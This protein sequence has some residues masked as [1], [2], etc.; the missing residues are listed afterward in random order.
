MTEEIYEYLFDLVILGQREPLNEVFDPY[1]SV[2]FDILPDQFI[3]VLPYDEPL[4]ANPIDYAW[5]QNDVI[6]LLLAILRIEDHFDDLFGDAE[7]FDA[8]IHQALLQKWSKLFY[9]SEL[10]GL[11]LLQPL[12]KLLGH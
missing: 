11:G 4:V 8:L 6:L 2:I 1:F 12:E 7:Q 5:H 3:E 10:P 9:L